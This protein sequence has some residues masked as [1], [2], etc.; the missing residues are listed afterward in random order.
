MTTI[1]L[2]EELDQPTREYLIR[3]RDGQDRGTPGIFVPT[4][5]PWP[6]LGCICGPIIVLGT[7]FFTL[8]SDTGI[9]FED[10]TR[11]AL[12]QTAGLL[13][14]GWM[15]IVA[16]ELPAVVAI[17][18]APGTVSGVTGDGPLAGPLPAVLTAR[19]STV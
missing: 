17:V 10:P 11:V 6:I 15:V 8:N 3:V 12:L 4:N 1:Y 5:N 19:T 18:G 13:V 7:L 9:V 2:L 14:G 16:L